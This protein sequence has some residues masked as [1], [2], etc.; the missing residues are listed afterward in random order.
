MLTCMINDELETGS[1]IDFPYVKD[2]GQKAELGGGM[3]LN[4]EHSV[5][6]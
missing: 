1:L 3:L 4:E 5:N 2:E 6:K